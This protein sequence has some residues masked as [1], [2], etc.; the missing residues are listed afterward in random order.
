MYQNDKQAMVEAIRENMDNMI[1]NG[2]EFN[3]KIPLI[4]YVFAM[5]EQSGLTNFMPDNEICLRVAA[6]TVY[7]WYKQH[8]RALRMKG[9]LTNG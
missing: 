1:S 4:D 6:M 5:H 7:R 3:T 9:Q 2:Y 8:K